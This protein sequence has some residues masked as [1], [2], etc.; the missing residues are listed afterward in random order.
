VL[1]VPAILLKPNLRRRL[2]FCR[3]HNACHGTRF[4]M[5]KK[6]SG[7]L[8]QPERVGYLIIIDPCDDFVIDHVESS[9]PSP[10]EASPRLD[11][12]V[13]RP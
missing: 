12:I 13:D 2:E 6:T 4:W 5:F 8:S 9:I 10:G 7:Q 1:V 3:K 11:N